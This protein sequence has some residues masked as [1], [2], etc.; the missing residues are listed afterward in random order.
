LIDISIND[1]EIEF[2]PPPQCNIVIIDEDNDV[3]HIEPDIVFLKSIVN[4]E[5]SNE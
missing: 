1:D 2:I 4:I 3:F 5:L